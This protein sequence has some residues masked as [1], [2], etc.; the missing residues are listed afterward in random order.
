MLTGPTPPPSTAL[1][2]RTDAAARKPDSPEKIKE[3]ASQFEALLIASL[4][5]TMRESSGWLSTGEEDQSG[6]HAM[7]FAEEQMAQALASQGGM[8]LAGLVADGL[9]KR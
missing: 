3:A 9:K 1:T 7:E 4:I 2:N 5:K 8:G 6:M